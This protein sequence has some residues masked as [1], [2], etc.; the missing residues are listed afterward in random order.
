MKKLP[1]LLILILC[2][3]VCASTGLARDYDGVTD[4]E[5]NTSALSAYMSVLQNNTP[6]ISAYDN[7]TMYINRVNDSIV[8]APMEITQFA[9]V[10]L[11]NDGL[12]EVILWL[13]VYGN[14]YGA[15]VLRYQDGVVYGFDFVYRALMQLKADGT[16]SFS[17]GASDNGFGTVKFE[18]NTYSIDEITY[19]QSDF[20]SN[21]NLSVSCFVNHEPATE[22]AFL[23]ALTEQEQKPD[24]AWYDFTEEN[25]EEILSSFR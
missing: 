21:N 19:C 1:F 3:P 17:G 20:D 24:A 16:F 11:D 25:I 23:S 5:I 13:T 9:V 12:A 10:D 18:K 4:V 14:A 7:Q 2:L 22:E 15:L 8:D 6:F